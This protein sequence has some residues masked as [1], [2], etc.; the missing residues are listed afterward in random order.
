MEG[1]HADIVTLDL[2]NAMDNSLTSGKDLQVIVLSKDN[3]VALYC[4]WWR[5]KDVR[6]GFACLVIIVK[7]LYHVVHD[8]TPAFAFFITV[9]PHLI[10][11]EEGGGMN[12]VGSVNCH[13]LHLL[14]DIIIQ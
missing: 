7:D 1:V 3:D 8:P 10:R 2:D 13:S 6:G 12:N 14:Q 5:V 4:L 9:I 11:L